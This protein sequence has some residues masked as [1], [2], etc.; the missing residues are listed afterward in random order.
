MTLKKIFSGAALAALLY[1]TAAMA[2]E[3]LGNVTFP[4]SCDP[5]VQTRFNRA[6]AMLHSFWFQQ[7]ETAFREVLKSD[8]K[9]AIANWGIAAILIGNTFAGNATAQD[10]QKAKEAIQQARLTGA[11]TERERFYIEAIA[12][13]WDRFADR[14]HGAYEVTRRCL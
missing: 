2:Q 6:V 11:K 9:C 13:Y 10:A 8:P 1:S 4:T 14:P 3:K 12:E 5:K 7:G